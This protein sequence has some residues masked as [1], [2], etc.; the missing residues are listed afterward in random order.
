MSTEE[1]RSVRTSFS[2]LLGPD[3]INVVIVGA[4]LT[5]IC[6]A[7]SAVERRANVVLIESATKLYR[8]DEI[9]RP[10]YINAVDP[11]RQGELGIVDSPELFF[12]QTQAAGLGRG[13]PVLQKALCYKAY[14]AVKWLESFGVHFEKKVRQIPGGA[15]PRTCVVKDSDAMRRK[16]LRAAT[17]AGVTVLS[18]MSFEDLYQEKTGRIH[19]VFVSDLNGDQHLLIADSVIMATGGFSGNSILCARH[20][21]RLR[22]LGSLRQTNVENGLRSIVRVGGYLVGMDFIELAFG[23]RRKEPSE[24]FLPSPFS[25]LDYILLNKAGRRV[26]NEADSEAVK[27]AV[28]N[29]ESSSLMLLTSFTTLKTLPAVWQRRME[30][31]LSEGCA[32]RISGYKDLHRVT[33]YPEQAWETLLRYNRPG[34]DELGKCWREQINVGDIF[35]IPVTFIRAV[36]LGGVCIDKEC[37]VLSVDGSVVEGLFA[38]GEI[39]GG[40]HGAHCLPGNLALESVVFG[41]EAGRSSVH[42]R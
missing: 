31:L 25:P 32:K 4:G 40:I 16:L 37:R 23:I 9:E 41:R 26:V 13:N 21:A 35:A 10:L 11:E 39:T 20:D 6:A 27:D 18:G 2:K 38:A 17:D 29:E 42:E 15:F 30:A 33:D 24:E 36:T 7:L 12:R 22:S 19:G 28:L 5:G 34:I 8:D 3:P 1:L 14:I